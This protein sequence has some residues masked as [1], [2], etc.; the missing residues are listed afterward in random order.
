MDTLALFDI[1]GTLVDGWKTHRQGF[2]IAIR[3]VTGIDA[4]LYDID[5]FGKVDRGA[6]YEILRMHG[7]PDKEIEGHVGKILDRLALHYKE[8]YSKEKVRILPGVPELLSRLKGVGVG[9]ALTTGNLEKIAH[10]KLSLAGLDSYFPIGG[11]G[12]EAMN[13]WGCAELAIKRAEDH[14][15]GTFTK[16]SMTGDTKL[17]IATGQRLKIKSIG[18]GTG[19]TSMDDLRSMKPDFLFKDLSDVEGVIQ[20]ITK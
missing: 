18:V 9:L 19:G 8:N 17:D 1:D 5:Y 12:N 16:I 7:M 15:G 11:F 10:L 20:A 14:Y 2:G 13:R 3:D 6:V 4:S